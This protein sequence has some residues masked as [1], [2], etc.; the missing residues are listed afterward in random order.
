[1]YHTN[2]I[3][4]MESEVE[5]MNFYDSFNDW[6]ETGREIEFTYMEKEYSVTYFKRNNGEYGISFCEFN[7]EPI[8]FKDAEEFMANA[9]IG[10]EL[11]CNIWEAVTD[12]EIF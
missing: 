10:D 7:C 5:K 3:G 2:T 4:K 11:L 6:I 8:S 1:M 9:K 12:I